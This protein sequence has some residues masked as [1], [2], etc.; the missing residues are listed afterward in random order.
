MWLATTG[1]SITDVF[2]HNVNI[3]PTNYCIV[4]DPPQYNEVA[5][6]LPLLNDTFVCVAIT[7]KLAGLSFRGS[8]EGKIWFQTPVKGDY[9]PAFSRAVLRDGQAYYMYF[10]LL[11]S[12]WPIDSWYIVG[13]RPSFTC[14]FLSRSTSNLF[15]SQSEGPSASPVR[16]SSTSLP[17]ACIETES[18]EYIQEPLKKTRACPQST[19]PRQRRLAQPQE[20]HFLQQ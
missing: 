11:T 10:L 18:L 2:Y 4:K 15:L 6:I 17:A 12:P 7:L 20:F 8:Q 1:S 13:P 3:G 14:S 16:Q 9:I 5:A 19:S